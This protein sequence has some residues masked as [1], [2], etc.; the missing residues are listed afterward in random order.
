MF[1]LRGS[2]GTPEKI[3]SFSRLSEEET[4]RINKE[5]RRLAQKGYR[6]LA[7]AS[8]K[9]SPS[10]ALNIDLE[11]IKN[12]TISFSGLIALRDALRKDVKKSIEICAEAGINTIIVTGDH[13]LTAQAIAEEMG[14]KIDNSNIIDGGELDEISDKE[15][16]ERIET[17]KV[18][19]RVEPRHKIRIIGAWQSKGR[20]IAMT[21]DGINDAP[22]LKKADMGIA[23]GSGTEVAKE[24]SDLILLD[25][26]FSIIVAAVEEGRFIM[27]NIKKV[28]TYLLSGGFA[29][30]VLIGAS[31]MAG[32]P[33]PLTATQILWI[34]LIEDSLPNMA[35]AFEPEEKDIMKN[36]PIS[37]KAPLLTKEMKTIIFVIGIVT[38]L[39]LLGLFF[40]L[41]HKTYDIDYV[42]TMI[43][44]CLA[45]DSLFYVFSCES[46]RKNIWDINIFSNKPLLL[47]V[48]AGFL[49]LAISIYAPVFQE[50]LKTVPLGI[51]DWMIIIGLGLL[52]VLLIEAV[53]W[54]F[55]KNKK[56]KI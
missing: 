46:L 2:C 56:N 31:I 36:K 32:L 53:K 41:W 26:K 49:M 18:F 33:L 35:L 5:L 12:K 37:K 30:V 13:K 48:G 24:A 38:D 34:N 42:R 1:G 15:L 17:I 7:S 28:I 29:E 51:T 9:L 39:I 16:R 55:I 19:A 43:F 20:V 3:I 23:I 10:E 50:L 11:N 44:A 14:M 22:A 25:N 21:G 4:Q 6:V 40:L 45:A 54:F 8:E 27:D 47:A 52:E